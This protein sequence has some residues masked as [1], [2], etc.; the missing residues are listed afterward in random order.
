MLHNTSKTLGFKKI[1]VYKTTPGGGSGG[2]KAYLDCG[3]YLVVT[4]SSNFV[5]CFGHFFELMLKFNVLFNRRICGGGVIQGQ[6]TFLNVMKMEL[7]S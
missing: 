6:I 5:S 7:L 3:L 4:F 1:M 2:G